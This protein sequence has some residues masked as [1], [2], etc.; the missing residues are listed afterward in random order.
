MKIQMR[1]D[2]RMPDPESLGRFGPLIPAAWCVDV[3]RAPR[4]EGYVLVDTGASHAAIAADAVRELGLVPERKG[5]ISHGPNSPFLASGYSATLMLPV[6]L[7]G[8]GAERHALGL[9]IT[10][11]RSVGNLQAL[12]SSESHRIIG[13]VGRTFLS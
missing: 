3:S 5:Q 6:A 4:V 8:G 10:D 12:V 1:I 2:E 7:A 9:N 13:L 11:A